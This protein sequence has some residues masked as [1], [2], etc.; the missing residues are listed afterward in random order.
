M[1]FHVDTSSGVPI[2]L[3]IVNQVKRATASGLLAEGD[4]MPSVRD[5]AVQ[6]TVNPNTVAKAYQELEREGVIKTSRGRGTFIAGEGVKL[7]HKERVRVV[8]EAIDKVLVE[9][10]HLGISNPELSELFTKR[11]E[12][13]KVKQ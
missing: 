9:A 11:L 10:H 2:Y 5:L 13:W 4:Q 12:E 1:W 6:L 7:I 3:Q 8:Q